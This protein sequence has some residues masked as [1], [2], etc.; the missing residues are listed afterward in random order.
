MTFEDRLGGE[1]REAASRPV[2]E[3]ARWDACVDYEIG[4]VVLSPTKVRPRLIERLFGKRSY[5]RLDRFIC[6]GHRGGRE[7][8]AEYP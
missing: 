3:T 5:T 2:P 4:D 7:T 1:L 8:W 6:T